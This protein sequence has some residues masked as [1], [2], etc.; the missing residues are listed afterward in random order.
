MYE[1]ERFKS[2][3][4]SDKYSG[5]Q[6]RSIL[7]VPV[8]DNVG[9]VIGLIELINKF[10]QEI[11]ADGESGLKVTAFTAQDERLLHLMCAHCSTFISHMG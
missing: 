1:D 9:R 10:E 11:H 4:L 8:K 2:N 6:S 7:I 3:R 5:Y